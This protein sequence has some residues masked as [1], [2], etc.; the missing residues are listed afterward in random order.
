[1]I[2]IVPA[3]ILLILHGPS[4]LDKM[5][6]EGRLP[7]RIAH[8][9]LS[10]RSQCAAKTVVP[11]V[12][13]LGSFIS[14]S[15]GSSINAW[16]SVFASFDSEWFDNSTAWLQTPCKGVVAPY[17]YLPPRTELPNGPVCLAQRSR[18]GPGIA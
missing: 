7:E 10:A 15:D 11:D 14:A 13:Q 3:L 9:A 1:M 5:A 17:Q 8:I 2:H 12:Q 16:L 6:E 4:G 18:D